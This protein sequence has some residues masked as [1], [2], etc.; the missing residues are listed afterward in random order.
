MGKFNLFNF[1]EKKIDVAEVHPVTQKILEQYAFKALALH[2]A[3]SYI[4]NTISKCEVKVYNNGKEVKDELYYRLNLSPNPNQN[5]SQFFN[6]L[7]EDYFYKGRAMV[8]PH[9]KHIYTVD[10]FDTDDTDYL[11]GNVYYNLR[12]HNQMLE[13]RYNS[14][15]IF[16]FEL[17]NRNVK[18]LVD[19]L[20]A[21][22]SEVI[23]QAVSSYKRSNGSKYKLK[24]EQYK[25]GDK[26]FEKQYNEVIA[27]QLRTFINN[28]NT[29]YPEFKGTVLEDFAQKITKDV[30][31]V[32][33]MRKEIFEVTAQAFKIPLSMMLGN[34]TNMN[35]IVKVYQSIC[36]DPIAD[37]LSEEFTRKYYSMQE[38]QNGSKIV[39]DTSCINYVDIL[40][41]AEKVDKAVSSGAVTIDELRERLGK[42]ALNTD[43]STA[44]FMTKNYALAEDLLNNNTEG[45]ENHESNE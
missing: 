44:H 15:D 26:V 14:D 12:I 28:D 17:D 27:E 10:S 36:I 39:V 30:S 38:W 41:V 25:A 3:I 43:F 2:I 23:G 29:V 42:E 20:Y 8:V 6:K 18:T 5:G 45:E 33:N 31:D 1:L 32:V 21:I 13:K 16:L 37:M 22:Y 40:E 35:E 11:R 24:L 7:V 34:V 4:A 9:G 19:G